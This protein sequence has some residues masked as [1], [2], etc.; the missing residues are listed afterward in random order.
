MISLLRNDDAGK[1]VLRLTLGSLMLFHGADKLLHPGSL[2][3][4]GS[5]LAGA[6]LPEI[7]AWGVYAGE[8]IAPLMI[9]LGILARIGGLLVVINMLFAILLMHSGDLFALTEHGGW[10][11]ELQGFYLFCGLAIMLLGSGK[12]AIKPD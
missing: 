4:I 1:L 12:L 3:F 9:I 11:L 5:K 2:N 8:I 7:I 6:G 10:R